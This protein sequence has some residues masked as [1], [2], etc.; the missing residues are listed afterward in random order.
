MNSSKEKNEASGMMLLSLTLFDAITRLVLAFFL[1][2]I[3][4]YWLF[5][6]NRNNYELFKRENETCG[7]ILL[8]LNLLE[9]IT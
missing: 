6:N 8:S 4:L 9:A 5:L 3:F 2:W 1:N 7:E